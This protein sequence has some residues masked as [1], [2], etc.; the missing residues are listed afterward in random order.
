MSKSR[1][2]RTCQNHHSLAILKYVLLRDNMGG[3]MHAG[4]ISGTNLT[5]QMLAKALRLNHL[6]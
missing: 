6:A 5:R 3:K 4:L 1:F 2:L